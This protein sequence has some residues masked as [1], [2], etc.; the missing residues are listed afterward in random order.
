MERAEILKQIAPYFEPR[1]LVCNHTWDRYKW[2]S[3]QFLDTLYLECLLIIRRD[4]LKKPMWCNNHGQGVFQ[5]GLRCNLC[6]LVKEKTLSGLLYQTQH[7]FGKAG[8]YTVEGMT[9]RQARELIIANAALLPCPIRL[10]DGVDWLHF[11]VLPQYGVTEKVHL[12]KA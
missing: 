12:F 5:R 11:D 2:S 1:E 4:I 3:W 8:D 10:E 9:A 6:N 7:G